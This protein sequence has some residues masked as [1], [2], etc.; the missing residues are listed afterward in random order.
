MMN[1]KL[2]GWTGMDCLAGMDGDEFQ[3][4]YLPT[5]TEGIRTYV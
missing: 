1:K 4:G 2:D 3:S 5:F